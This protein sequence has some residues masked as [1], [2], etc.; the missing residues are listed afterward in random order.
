MRPRNCFVVKFT[1]RADVRDY[2]LL[3]ERGGRGG[4]TY[5]GEVPVLDRVLTPG[6]QPAVMDT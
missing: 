4:G 3:L 6:E 1:S 5:P 2:C